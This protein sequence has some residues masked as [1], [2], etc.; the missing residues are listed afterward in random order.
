MEQNGSN[1]NQAAGFIRREYGH[2]VDFVRS[3][4]GEVESMEP[5]D[6]VQDVLAGLF[7]KA[8]ISAPI[9]NLAAYVYRSLRNR[10]VDAWRARRNQLSLDSPAKGRSLADSLPAAGMSAAELMELNSRWRLL[11]EEMAGLGSADRAIIT[12]T[13]LEGWTFRELSEEWD[14]PMGTLLARK[15]RALKKLKDRIAAREV[16]AKGGENDES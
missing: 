4:L 14:V 1:Q 3:R 12:A 2:L 15:S 9:H 10:V 6:I 7:D 16:S 8:D 11:G 5:E 13:E